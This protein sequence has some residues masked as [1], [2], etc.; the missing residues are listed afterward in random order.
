MERMVPWPALYLP[1]SPL[2]TIALNNFQGGTAA[3]A[4]LSVWGP[5]NI[6]GNGSGAQ[7]LG[8]GLV[9]KATSF[10]NDGSR[11][12]T[13]TEFLNGQTTSDP[14]RGSGSAEL[15]EQGTADPT[16]L[17]ATLNSLRTQQPTLL[18]PLA[19]VTDV[20]LYRVFV[21]S[22][23]TGIHLMADRHSA[24]P[25][26]AMLSANP[27]AASPGATKNRYQQIG[28]RGPALVRPER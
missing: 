12:S 19:S 22:A 26:T 27:A 20:R 2:P 25:P 1:H 10:F 8:L 9:G 11:P 17:T 3:L 24:T 15:P 4:N 7:V 21:D 23:V 28:R 16:F 5:I 6:T 18:A 14:P 13:T